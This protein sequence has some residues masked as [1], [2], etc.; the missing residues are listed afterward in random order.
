MAHIFQCFHYL[1]V[2]IIKHLEIPYEICSYIFLNAGLKCVTL[3]ARILWYQILRPKKS[4]LNIII[5]VVHASSN[6]N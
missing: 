1:T 4:V 2:N 5:L 6:L 3:V